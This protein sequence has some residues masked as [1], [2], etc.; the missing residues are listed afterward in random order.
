MQRFGESW[1][2][3]RKAIQNLAHRAIVEIRRGTECRFP[4][5]EVVMRNHH[6]RRCASPRHVG[7]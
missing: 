1:P 6:L 7:W 2:T 5:V 4:G 3:G